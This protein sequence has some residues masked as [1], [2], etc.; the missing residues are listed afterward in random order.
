MGY[1]AGCPYPFALYSSPAILNNPG[2]LNGGSPIALGTP[3]T[4][5]CLSSNSIS[6]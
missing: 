5:S 4:K 3:H 2:G 1:L 6:F